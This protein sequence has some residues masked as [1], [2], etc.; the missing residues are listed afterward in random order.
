MRNVKFGARIPVSGP[1]SNSERL[2][3]STV[4]AERLGYD[5]VFMVDHIHNSFERHKQYP[6]GMG[7]YRDSTNTLDPHQFETVAAFSF[8]AGMTKKIEFGVGVMPL[9]LREPIVLAKELATM[10]A[11]SA[12][13]FILGVGVSNVSD[14]EEYVSVGK[15]FSPYAER[16]EMIGEYVSAMR[17]IWEKPT[18]SFQ[19]KHVRF[20]N[21]TIYPK[22]ARRIPVWVGCY[23]LAGGKGRPAVKFALEHA[24]GWM[25]GFLMTPQHVKAMIQD[26]SKTAK[27]S[28]RDIS[29]FDWCFQL[30]LSIGETMEEARKNVEWI[31]Q[32]QPHMARF[33]GYM[34][35]REDTWRDAKGAEEA[36]KS[37]VETAVVGTPDTIKKRIREFID[38]GANYFDLWFMY[39][40]YDALMKQMSLFAKEV[41]P[42]FR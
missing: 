23:T 16:Y 25:Y 20:E 17:A 30:R 12:G 3:E 8:L 41:L 40:R 28:G 39:P 21:L 36:P 14:K 37:N 1:V 5:T 26:F 42:A 19:G 29:N 4:E 35:K 10:D 24:D 31:A 38:A 6:V 18:A 13:R 27:E 33:A 15:P 2:I 7:S 32:D 11:L 9:P 34:W 22:P